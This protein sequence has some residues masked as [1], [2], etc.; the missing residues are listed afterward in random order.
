MKV[1][2]ILTDSN[3]GGAGKLLYN[4]SSCIDRN[5]FEFVFLFAKNS[6]LIN[7]FMPLGFKIYTLDCT[8]DKSFDVKSI[9]QIINILKKENPQIL[10]THSSLSGKIALKLSL[11][12][13]IKSIYTKHCVFGTPKIMSLSPIK[14]IYG[15]MDNLLSDHIIAVAEAAKDEL[16][17][18]GVNKRKIK[19]I[20]NGSRRLKKL[21]EHEKCI[22]KQNKRSC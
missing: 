3:I 16:I 14:I 11:K 13:N 15:I 1:M 19:V 10:H 9:S 4:I 8:P 17:N 6:K 7:L 2:H 22:I 18:Y 21:S 20:V 5:Q 12:H